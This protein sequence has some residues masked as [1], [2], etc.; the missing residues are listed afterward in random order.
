MSLTTG[1]FSSGFVK[2]NNN[3]SKLNPIVLKQLQAFSKPLTFLKIN[4]TPHQYLW[5]NKNVLIFFC[6]LSI[7]MHG[8]HSNKIT[9]C[10][11]MQPERVF[12]VAGLWLG[13]CLS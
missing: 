11:Q 13:F 4:Y 1:V 5:R 12:L 8:D 6:V 10:A 3:K 9:L 2:I 7:V